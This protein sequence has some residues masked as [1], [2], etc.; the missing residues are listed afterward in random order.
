MCRFNMSLNDAVVNE[1]RPHFS[2][3]ESLL[4]WM[5][6]SLEHLMREYATRFRKPAV[7]GEQLLKKLKS[8]PD[9]PEGF[10]QLAGILGRPGS[11]FSWGELR[12]ESYTEKYGI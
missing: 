11:S 8:L 10:L 3:E 2:D 9:T 4:M 1:I 12:G 7:D 6:S 5:E